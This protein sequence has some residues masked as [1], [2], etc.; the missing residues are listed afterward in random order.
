MKPVAAGTDL[1]QIGFHAS[2]QRPRGHADG[3]HILYLSAVGN[4]DEVWINDVDG[5][6][7][8]QLSGLALESSALEG[9]TVSEFA[10]SPDGNEVAVAR[11]VRVAPPPIGDGTGRLVV[12]RSEDPVFFG[13]SFDDLAF[14]HITLVDLDSGQ[15]RVL[16]KDLFYARN[17]R[18]S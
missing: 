2:G 15:E 7:P 18:L 13:A 9:T 6:N 10:L 12:A 17:L 8:R 16:K 1:A 11:T 14:S 3:R 5:L 4:R